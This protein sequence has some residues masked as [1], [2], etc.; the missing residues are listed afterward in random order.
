MSKYI[1]AYKVPDGYLGDWQTVYVVLLDKKIVHVHP[2]G[3]YLSP[4]L[5]S[6]MSSVE[7]ARWMIE[8]HPMGRRY[9]K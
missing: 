5:S 3:C 4:Y 6:E 2:H 8:N 7:E 1:G 9:Y